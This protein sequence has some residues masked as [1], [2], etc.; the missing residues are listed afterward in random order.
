MELRKIPVRSSNVP[1]SGLL[2]KV[3]L[4]NPTSAALVFGLLYFGG[5]G[6]DAPVTGIEFS[7]S[8]D[9]RRS[10][11]YEQSSSSR[12]HLEQHGERVS[13]QIIE[14]M[15][16]HGNVPTTLLNTLQST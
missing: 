12:S 15:Q 13:D 3:S 7:S 5:R 9:A 8:R 2:C 1:L 10:R 6:E 4:T 14:N 16:I 11:W